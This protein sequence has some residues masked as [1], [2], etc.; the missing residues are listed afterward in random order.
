MDNTIKIKLAIDVYAQI[1][2]KEKKDIQEIF[3]NPLV[4]KKDN[5]GKV[6]MAYVATDGFYYDFGIADFLKE[7]TQEERDKLLILS[8]INA[9]KKEL[10]ALEIELE[11]TNDK[12]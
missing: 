2:D 1:T 11:N 10:A 12:G 5:T 9:K 7:T 3:K 6:V 8:K 4:I